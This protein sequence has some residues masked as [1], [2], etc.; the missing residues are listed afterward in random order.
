MK[1]LVVEDNVRLAERIKSV[2]Q[3]VYVV[4]VAHAGADALL[5]IATTDYVAIILDLGLPDMS[6]HAVCDKVRS[7]RVTVPILILTG[8]N[9][10]TSK[11]KLLD[12]GADDYLAKPF[13]EDELKAR[14]KALVRRYTRSRTDAMMSV[15]D[16]TIDTSQRIAYRAGQRVEL[17][18]KEFDILEYLV[19]NKGRVLTREMIL[20]HAW[21]STRN[22]WSS[23]VDV[24]I[25][26]LRDKIDRPFQ[27]AVIKTEYGIG[28]RVDEMAQ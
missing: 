8:E 14:V 20:N 7:R 21:D 11:V 19:T 16:L 25:K 2:L 12:S 22:G 5:T 18:R 9:D 15:G 23:T 27:K 17:R 1:V 6:G 24:H 26:H 10:V 13:H 3:G 4:D 28:Y